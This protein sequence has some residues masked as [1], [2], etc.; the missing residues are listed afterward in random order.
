ML[1]EFTEV[2]T[3]C[4]NFVESSVELGLAAFAVSLEFSQKGSKSLLL[5]CQGLIALWISSLQMSSVEAAN[6]GCWD[7]IVVDRD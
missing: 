3:H 5:R 6:L 7:W 1:L 2:T 4:R